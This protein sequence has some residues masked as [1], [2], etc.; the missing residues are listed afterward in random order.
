M[1]ASVLVVRDRLPLCCR[2]GVMMDIYVQIEVVFQ[3]L[4]CSNDFD[5]QNVEKQKGTGRGG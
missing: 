1:V 5:V 4:Y 3:R 2:W